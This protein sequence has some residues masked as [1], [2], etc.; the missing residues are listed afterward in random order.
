MWEIWEIWNN[1][2]G[3]KDHEG[4]GVN[5]YNPYIERKGDGRRIKQLFLWCGVFGGCLE[6]G[7]GGERREKRGGV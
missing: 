3:N 6:E 7:R 1:V 2:C 5:V 4:N